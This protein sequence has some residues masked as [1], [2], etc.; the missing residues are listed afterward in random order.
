MV[1][2]VSDRFLHPAKIIVKFDGR[3]LPFVARK[4]ARDDVCACAKYDYNELER[5]RMSGL[6]NFLNA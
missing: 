1:V 5:M 2:E 6:Q 3:S 4:K